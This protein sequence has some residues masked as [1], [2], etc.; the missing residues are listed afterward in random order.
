G[1][2]KK[3]RITNEPGSSPDRVVVVVDV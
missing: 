3:V 1:F 2:F